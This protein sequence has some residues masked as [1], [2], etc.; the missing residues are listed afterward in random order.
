MYIYIYMCTAI[1]H[2]ACTMTRVLRNSWPH[3]H[4]HKN[5]KINI[6][7]CEL[8]CSSITSR[9]ATEINLINVIIRSCLKF[10]HDRIIIVFYLK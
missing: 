9:T 5:R 7:T 6:Y 3:L 2:L 10:A 1:L 8:I 4:W